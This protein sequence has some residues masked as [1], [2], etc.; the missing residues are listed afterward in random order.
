LAEWLTRVTCLVDAGAVG[1]ELGAAGELER[2]VRLF[3]AAC[4]TSAHKYKYR[5]DKY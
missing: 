1:N 2:V 5:W 3:E 4:A